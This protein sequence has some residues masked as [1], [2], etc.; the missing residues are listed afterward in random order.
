MSKGFALASFIALYF[1]VMFVTTFVRL[2]VGDPVP[3]RGLMYAG[4]FVLGWYMMRL[5]GLWKRALRVP[6]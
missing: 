2:E 4:Y 6:E 1:A 5:W 3:L